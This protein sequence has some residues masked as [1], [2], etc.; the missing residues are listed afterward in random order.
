[1]RPLS[2][3]TDALPSQIYTLSLHDALPICAEPTD[4]AIPAARPAGRALAPELLFRD[5]AHCREGTRFPRPRLGPAPQMSR[6]EG[7]AMN[8]PPLRWQSTRIK[9]A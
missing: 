8:V 5:R 4:R 7:S 9:V 2:P 1:S 3:V 6:R